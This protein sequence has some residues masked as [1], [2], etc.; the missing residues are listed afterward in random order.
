M[1][2]QKENLKLRVTAEDATK[3]SLSSIA[4]NIKGVVGAYIGLAAIKGII[5]GIVSAGI[6]HEKVWNDIAAALDRHGQSM[7]DSLLRI[8]KFSDEM[9]T[10]S[11]ISDEVIGKSVQ[12]F[13]DYGQTAKE[14]MDTTRVA[15]D[16]AAG[17]G[18]SL[19]SATELLAK[20]AVGYT[21]TLSRYGI[22]LDETLS[23]SEKFEAAL[24]LIDDRFG[25]A[26]Q[27]RA[28]NF[29]TKLDLLSERFG[30]LNEALF[31]IARGGGAI[32]TLIDKTSD[33]IGTLTGF[34]NS[35]IKLWEVL[36]G[37]IDI[38]TGRMDSFL[39]RADQFDE[40]GRRIDETLKGLKLDDPFPE[41]PSAIID[42]VLFENMLTQ[43]QEMLAEALKE[44]EELIE[45]AEEVKLSTQ[46]EFA[47][48]WRRTQV[49]QFD[50]AMQ[51]LKDLTKGALKEETKAAKDAQDK[52]RT[53]T[54]A[55]ESIMSRGMDQMVKKIVTGK[56]EFK[57]IFKGIADDFMTF[58]IKQALSH[59]TNLFIPGLGSLLG[60]IFDTPKNDRMA[61]EQGMH[62]AQFFT[63]GTMD[64]MENFNMASTLSGASG[65]NVGSQAQPGLASGGGV[66]I[67]L[68]VNGSIY[69]VDHLNQ[70]IEDTVINRISRIKLD[71]DMIT[72]E[73]EISV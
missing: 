16:L 39:E 23:D 73:R 11:G 10:L 15:M 51:M 47:K 4:N 32:D 40:F 14:A 24:G 19:K 41:H 45:D 44:E 55:M 29:G 25:G 58:F 57:D 68:Q 48:I 35:D 28:E 52:I 72:G 3:G 7:D 61:M 20:A 42:P 54:R 13:V 63:K 53:T 36:A 64:F 38:N 5:S 59:I 66:N 6:E 2:T 22:I 70:V 65:F 30:D 27:A 12:A 43:R 60:S 31:E 33:G 71:D 34:L 17:S 56:G 67:T 37:W 46:T 69:G 9:Q 1:A 8:Q 49:E 62:F 21:G 18:M 26:A 50:F